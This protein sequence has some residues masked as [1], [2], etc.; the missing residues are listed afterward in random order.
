MLDAENIDKLSD[1]WLSF[2]QDKDDNRALQLYCE[3]IVPCLLPN[4]HKIFE[5]T[6]HK[7][8]EYD[9]LISLLGFTPDTVVL[10]YQ[11]VR[12]K[13][14]VVLHTEET[15][16]FLNT[17]VRFAG[18]PLSGFFHEPFREFPYG[19]IYRALS[20]ALK[21]FPREARVAIELTGGKKTMGGALAVAA[22]MLNIDLLYIDYDEYMPQF[23][24]PKPKSTYIHLVGNPMKL[25]TDL[26]GNSEIERAIEFF[27]V[28]KYD[29]SKALF[30][31]I[32]LRMTTPRA[33]EFG[34]VLSQFYLSWDIF[35][36][37]DAL[38]HA[39]SLSYQMSLFQDEILSLFRFNL[40]RLQ[41]Q[42][43]AIRKLA[44]EDR[45]SIMWNFYFGALRH[46]K[47]GQY[48]LAVLLYYRTLEDILDNAL[49]DIVNEF[50]RSNPNYSLF[51]MELEELTSKFMKFRPKDFKESN[52]KRSLP[53]PIA[54]FDAFCLLG[55]LDA[56]LTRL[57]NVSKV[58]H[59]ASK[60]NL[61]VYA[62]G[63]HAM[64]KSALDLIRSFAHKMICAYA[65]IKSFG[66]LDHQSERFEFM[67][68]T[69]REK[70]EDFSR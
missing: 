39:A 45:Q 2:L 50:D 27:N 57:F 64:D 34:A 8:A 35:A 65:D 12:P 42:F 63:L 14:F 52:I 1:Q 44:N 32:S 51:G 59:I 54:M 53:D 33:V 4:L 60:R 49:K 70:T 15:K 30:E 36:F 22:G 40:N 37:D 10:A 16:D 13:I 3:K 24:K 19:D 46:E 20:A 69:T 58:R 6:F 29:I 43:E 31:S 67:E 5:E 25:S 23:R 41:K 28:G 18:I 66:P 68:L 47:N 21:R 17:V 48:D 38:K 55:T 7:R 26:F 61:S 56:P 9:G 62:H 11:F